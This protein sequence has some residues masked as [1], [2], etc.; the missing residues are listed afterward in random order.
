MFFYSKLCNS[1]MK[2][3]LFF[4]DCSVVVCEIGA[5]QGNPISYSY[6][7]AS[8]FS[9]SLSQIGIDECLSAN[10]KVSVPQR[11]N[12]SQIAVF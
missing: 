12:M 4:R 8:S 10:F 2:L 11:L 3:D 9:V 1:P 6:S 5:E 7:T